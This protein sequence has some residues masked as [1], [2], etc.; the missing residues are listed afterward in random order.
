M[1]MSFRE[2]RC[3]REKQ[4]SRRSGLSTAINSLAYG[5]NVWNEDHHKPFSIRLLLLWHQRTHERVLINYEIRQMRDV[6]YTA[7]YY[8][9]IHI[10]EISNSISSKRWNISGHLREWPECFCNSFWASDSAD[11]IDSFDQIDCETIF[12]S[13]AVGRFYYLIMQRQRSQI[14]QIQS[15]WACAWECR[16]NRKSH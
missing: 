14:V 9:R 2:I 6:V 16:I 5:W 12:A 10:H 8:T 3:M 4:P 7:Y 1:A 15:V 13:K 11:S